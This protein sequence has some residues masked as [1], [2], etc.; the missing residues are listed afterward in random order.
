MTVRYQQID[1]AASKAAAREAAL[2]RKT[3]E[4]CALLRIWPR[5]MCA[6]EKSPHFR[7]VRDTY[8]DRCE[9]YALKG[10]QTAP[11]PPPAPEPARPK[12]KRMKLVRVRGTDRVVSADE[13]D[14][15]LARSRAGRVSP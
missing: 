7:T 13:Y 12:P 4:G 15:L 2:Q 14:R 9:F 10:V 3:C 11:E 6:G 5:P 8:H 1:M